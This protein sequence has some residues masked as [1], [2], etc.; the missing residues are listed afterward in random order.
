[1]ILFSTLQFQMGNMGLGLWIDQNEGAK[2]WL[3]ILIE[4]QNRG[5]QDIFIAAVDGLTGL[6]EAINAVF[7]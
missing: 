7:P 4:L 6:P 2:F 1:M 3:G 5:V